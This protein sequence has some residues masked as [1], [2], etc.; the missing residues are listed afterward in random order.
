MEC[1]PPHAPRPS[2]IRMIL[3]LPEV[4][5]RC[6]ISRSTIYE[7]MKD[8]RFPKSRSLG[9]RAVGWDSWEIERWITAK[10]ECTHEQTAAS[11]TGTGRTDQNQ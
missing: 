7:W 6:G 9:S 10:L 8:G 11:A 1:I 3:R 4:I 2:P 5:R